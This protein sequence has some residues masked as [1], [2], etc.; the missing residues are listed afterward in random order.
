[1]RYGLLHLFFLE[2]D[3]LDYHRSRSF[4]VLLPC[5]H[6]LQRTIPSVRTKYSPPSLL[7]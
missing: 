7:V 4:S 1:M 5:Y 2:V 3:S 6:W